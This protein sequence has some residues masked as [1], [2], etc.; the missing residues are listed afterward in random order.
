M[1]KLI[2]VLC[3]VAMMLMAVP[4]LANPSASST[5]TVV[6]EGVTVAPVVTS[7]IADDGAKEVVE[8]VNGEGVMT[9]SEA[10][11]AVLGANAD[12]M[13]EVK[14]YSFTSQFNSIDA[15]EFPVDIEIAGADAATK[16]MLINPETGELVIIEA[17]DDGT[18]TIPFAGLFATMDPTP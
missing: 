13:D 5:V 11:A 16:I 1:R 12:E 9:P 8:A 3:V 6:T 4:A 10:V 18:F 15:P 14:G 7:G 2:A 17:N